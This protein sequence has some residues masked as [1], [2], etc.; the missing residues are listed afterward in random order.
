MHMYKLHVA[1]L[2]TLLSQSRHY[3]SGL[4]NHN[5]IISIHLLGYYVIA[6]V[7]FCAAH[8]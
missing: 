1:Q 8:M 5:T 4:R 6:K 2:M 3:I 7:V